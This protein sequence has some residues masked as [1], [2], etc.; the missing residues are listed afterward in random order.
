M[1]LI[2]ISL[3]SFLSIFPMGCSLNPFKSTPDEERFTYDAKGQ[4]V[5]GKSRGGPETPEEALMSPRIREKTSVVETE[6]EE[7]VVT[8][9]GEAVIVEETAVVGEVPLF[10]IVYYARGPE[11]R[12][13]GPPS[14]RPKSSLYEEAK[15]IH[16]AHSLEGSPYAAYYQEIRN[17]V[18][19]HWNFL[20]SDVEGINYK[21]V[22]SHPIVID[23]RIYPTGLISDVD[24]VNAAG[25]PVL[26]AL[27]K[28]AIETALVDRFP[29][30]IKAD[31][32]DLRFQ[33]YFEN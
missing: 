3:I 8:P 32:I 4:E 11:G 22:G 18:K 1:R 31:S 15:K 33:W 21:T 27:A 10:T 7:L 16:E 26:A 12:A 29:P 30:E 24:I 19:A 25:N 20:Y 5:E 9:G 13:K 6:E 2:F 23:A 28:G 14:D 17:R